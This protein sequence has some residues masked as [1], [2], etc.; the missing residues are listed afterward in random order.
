MSD[1]DLLYIDDTQCLNDITS[2][3]AKIKETLGSEG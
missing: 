3:L 2:K 1:G